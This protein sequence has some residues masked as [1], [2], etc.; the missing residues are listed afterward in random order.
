[1]VG[2]PGS[3]EGSSAFWERVYR[4]GGTS[5]TGS[6]GRLAEFKASVINRVIAERGVTSVIELGCGDGAQVSLIDYDSYVGLDVSQ[7]ALAACR[8]RFA[9]DPG[10]RF[11]LYGPELELPGADL[12]LSLD[13]IYHLLEDDVYVR[14]MSDLFASAGRYVLIYSS[15][16]DRAS[17]WDEVR[18]RPFSEWVA[19]HQ[20]HWRL[21]ER[22]EQR[23]PYVEGDPDTSWSDFH[24]YERGPR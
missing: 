16:S 20:P 3:I 4:E 1:V 9:D 19:R 12:A 14:Y 22:V 7:S 24:L 8:A 11:E 17:A 21:T 6:A 2:P 15:D 23:Y 13:V 10:K 18:H 5:G